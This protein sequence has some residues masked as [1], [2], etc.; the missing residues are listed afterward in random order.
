M[1]E[2]KISVF[3]ICF[4]LTVIL[5]VMKIAGMIDISNFY[6][7]LPLIIGVAWFVFIV[8]LIGLMTLYL[9]ATENEKEQNDEAGSEEEA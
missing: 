1:G 4:W 8:F 5:G 9:Y 3:K 7:F 2:T 6:V